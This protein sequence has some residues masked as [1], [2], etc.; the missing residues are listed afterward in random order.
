MQVLT[1]IWYYFI[2]HLGYL[3]IKNDV[4]SSSLFSYLLPFVVFS[5]TVHSQ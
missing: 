5:T 2:S 3:N 4:V 1:V